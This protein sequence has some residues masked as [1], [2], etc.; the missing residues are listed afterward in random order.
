M[1]TNNEY[2]WE[3][4]VGFAVLLR[5]NIFLYLSRF[6]LVCLVV[7]WRKKSKDLFKRAVCLAVNESAPFFSLQ[8]QRR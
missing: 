2:G 4:A 3:F 7:E 1:G 8:T 6:S 5:S